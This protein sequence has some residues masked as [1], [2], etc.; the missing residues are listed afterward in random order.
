MS[1]SNAIE[2]QAPAVAAAPAEE[3]LTDIERENA[4]Y[5]ENIVRN[6]ELDDEIARREAEKDGN[7]RKGKGKE[8]GKAPRRRRATQRKGK[9][10]GDKAPQGSK[11]VEDDD[12]EAFQRRRAMQHNDDDND[13]DDGDDGDDDEGK[14]SSK[15]WTTESITA[16]LEFI[17]TNH[18]RFDKKGSGYKP[19][20]WTEMRRF[21]ESIG[22]V[23]T[24]KQ[25][26]NKYNNLKALWIQREWLKNQSGFGIDPDTMRITAPSACWEDLKRV[27]ISISFI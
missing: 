5:V 11:E 6:M 9:D 10:N 19:Q 3:S 27:S 21:L 23:R 1:P 17:L 12:F 15:L 16:M 24:K 7:K 2:A 26:Q 22:L 25:L 8:K 14:H 20:M 18:Q 4:E 13:N